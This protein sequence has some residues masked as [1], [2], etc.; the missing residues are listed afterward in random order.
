MGIIAKVGVALQQ[1]FGTIAEEAAGATKIIVR[2][3]KFTGISLVRTFVL[4]FLQNP[5][6]SDEDLAQ[7]AKR[8]GVRGRRLGTQL[9]Q[10]SPTL[11]CRRAP[12]WSL[13]FA[14][15]PATVRCPY[16]TQAG[17]STAW[18]GRGRSVPG[19]S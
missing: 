6:A 2:K 9:V 18:A 11:L 8:G 1:L 14:V 16:R 13:L 12:R 7:M 10:G 19:P 4:G 5:E 15:A 17:A 3:R